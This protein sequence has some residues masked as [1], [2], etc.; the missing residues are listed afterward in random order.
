MTI[1]TLRQCRSVKFQQRMADSI[2]NGLKM[3]RRLAN[4]QFELREA[5]APRRTPS[6]RLQALVGEHAQ[7]QTQLTPESHHRINTYHAHTIHR[8]GAVRA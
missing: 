4:S 5:R 1:Q 3:M 7:R 2:S 6:H 8:Q